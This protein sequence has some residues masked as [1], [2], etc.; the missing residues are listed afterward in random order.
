[1]D[2]VKLDEY[3]GKKIRAFRL[4][5][6]WPLKVLASALQV[7]IQQVQRYEQGV[8]K[9]SAS[10]L[11]KL[12]SVFQIEI[13]NFFDGYNEL[14]TAPTTKKEG[15]N[16]LLIDDDLNDEF[17][18][19]KALED[20][21]KKL[22]IYTIHDGNK[23]LDFFRHINDGTVTQ[24]PKPDLIL[25]DLY[26]NG[27]KGFD[28]LRDIKKRS[29][30]RDIPVIMLTSSINTDDVTSS[31]HLHASGFIRKSFSFDEFKQQCHKAFEYW[32]QAVTLPS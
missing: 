31:Y 23:A 12:A 30:L 11:F 25:L 7:S 9:I 26:L 29:N 13:T 8:N 1:M 2:T 32:T 10:L 5:M 15:F 21:P 3:I 24:L 17:L 19:R 6:K 28:I 4:K 20:F 16:V 22:N 14:G 27:M 18:T